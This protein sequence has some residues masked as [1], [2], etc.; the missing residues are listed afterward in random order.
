MT[1]IVNRLSIGFR[2]NWRLF[3]WHIR[4]RRALWRDLSRDASHPVASRLRRQMSGRRHL[5]ILRVCVVVGAVLLILMAYA[6]A[7]IDHDFIWTLPIW[8]ML[9]SAVY[10]AIWIARIVPLMAK[11]SNFGVLDEISV[12]PPGRVFIYLTICKVVLN[13]DDA[14]LW[15]GLLRRAL[16]G[17]ALLV[18]LL[19][20]CIAFSLLA[21]RSIIELPA[22][23]I[24]LFFA[25]AVIWIE[26]S[27][28][29]A[30]AC[31]IAIEAP[32]RFG[33]KIDQTVVAIFVFALAQLLSYTAALSAVIA[34][35]WFSL[36]VMLL[37]FILLRELII[38]ALWRLVLHRA[39]EDNFQYTRNRRTQPLGAQGYQDRLF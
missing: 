22:I 6:Y 37:L 32:A 10:C 23:L 31:L 29:S 13:R 3:T 34:L 25:A 12:I 24:D 11:Q 21:E 28:S 19:T 26:H 38:S 8:L 9:F 17:L 2:S 20:L 15:L 1:R 36:G 4:A 35:N 39:N 16:A 30:L 27:Q 18:L 14:V 7:H 5:P 33:G